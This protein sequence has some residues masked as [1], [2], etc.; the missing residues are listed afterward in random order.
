MRPPSLNIND[1]PYLMKRWVTSFTAL[2]VMAR[3]VSWVTDRVVPLWSRSRS[4][5]T[6]LVGFMKRRTYPTED[7]ATTARRIVVIRLRLIAIISRSF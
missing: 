2:Q 5:R 1:A 7:I 4:R 3:S 6:F